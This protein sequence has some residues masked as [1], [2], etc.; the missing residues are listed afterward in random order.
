MCVCK[1]VSKERPQISKVRGE[2]GIVWSEER[3]RKNDVIIIS[4]YI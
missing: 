1:W 3:E 2:H 4:K